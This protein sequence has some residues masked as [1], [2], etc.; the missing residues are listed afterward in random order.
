MKTTE[1]NLAQFITSSIRTGGLEIEYDGFIKNTH[2]TL[3]LFV[4]Y[5]IDD[6]SGGSTKIVELRPQEEK[7]VMSHSCGP[8]FSG[9]EYGFEVLEVKTER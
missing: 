5:R 9:N 7:M 4:K 6:D 3:T 8:I 2:T 1:T